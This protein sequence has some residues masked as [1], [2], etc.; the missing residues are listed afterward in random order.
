[1]SIP[2]LERF[3]GLSAE[4]MEANNLF[5]E[6]GTFQR[7]ELDVL[8]E[9]MWYDWLLLKKHGVELG[10]V[11][12]PYFDA[13]PRYDWKRGP[14]L[15]HQVYF[16]S[17][18]FNGRS[19]IRGYAGSL[20]FGLGFDDSRDV[21]RG[22][23]DRFSLRG[24]AQ[25]DCWHTDSHELH[26]RYAPPNN[27]IDSVVVTLPIRPWPESGRTALF[28]GAG[29]WR[30]L[31]GESPSSPVLA[32]ALSP[33]NIAV[34]MQENEDEREADFVRECGLELYFEDVRQLR[35]PAK[36]AG[37]LGLGAVKFFRA[38][39][40]E[41][42]EW[43]GELPNGLFFD[44]SPDELLAKLG[45]RPDLHRDGRLTGFALWHFDDVSLHVLYSNFENHI[46][47]VTLM[48]AGYWLDSMEL[49]D[50]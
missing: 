2:D 47:R 41:A 11:S 34:R 20:P 42:R 6:L 43:Q 8:D 22:K 50:R 15:C 32:E 44:D 28:L 38:R 36:G 37:K 49:N 40:R 31:F 4:S 23:M 7:P 12:Q 35:L 46:L 33:L 9:Y 48:S 27:A 21:V 26:V 25:T 45:R 24:A 16:Y 18:G 10:F 1:M 13:Q 5:D 19:D 17:E 3:L 29:R 14:L 30:A 39:D